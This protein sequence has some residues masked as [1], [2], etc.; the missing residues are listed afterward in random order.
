MFD[1][2][3][4]VHV[5]KLL[6]RLCLDCIVPKLQL[7]TSFELLEGVWVAFAVV[8][9]RELAGVHFLD[10]SRFLRFGVVVSGGYLGLVTRIHSARLWEFDSIANAIWVDFCGRHKHLVVQLAIVPCIQINLAN[11]VRVLILGSGT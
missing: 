10:V 8:V 5:V 2:F 1:D 3:A 6:E 7:V 9:A 4:G 11:I